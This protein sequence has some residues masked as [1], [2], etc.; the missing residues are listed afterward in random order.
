MSVAQRSRDGARLIDLATDADISKSTCHRLALQLV[1]LG[2]LEHDEEGRRFFP[3][4]VWITMGAAAA[5]N[6]GLN[7]IVAPALERIARA[8]HD[9]VH[10]FIRVG[11]LAMCADMI[12]G[13]YPV[14]TI[15]MRIGER[16]PLGIG[17]GS[18][19]ILAA[20]PEAEIERILSAETMQAEVDSRGLTLESLREHVARARSNG[21]S[22]ND[23]MVV[24]GMT[25][26]GVAIGP[27]RQPAFASLSVAALSQRLTG[28]RREW[29]V[30][31]LRTEAAAILAEFDDIAHGN[32]HAAKR[33]LTSNL[34]G[35]SSLGRRVE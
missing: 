24:E 8:T 33:L 20:L 16:R 14:K 11:D 25:G 28:P 12:I 15:V 6:H 22:L 26:V 7:D 31:L 2:L 13:D 9:T 30:D 3:G 21:Y 18:L 27:P 23:G 4:K 10:F 5:N 32:H 35:S 1:Q 29:V 34:I 17:A 19:A